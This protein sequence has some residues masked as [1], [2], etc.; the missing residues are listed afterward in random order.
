MF[1]RLE[2][3]ELLISICK[4]EKLLRRHAVK[5]FDYALGI[6]SLVDT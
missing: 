6:T 4:K 1:R 5:V 2:G 3:F